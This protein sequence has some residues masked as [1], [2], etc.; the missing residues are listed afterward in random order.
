MD[1]AMTEV[2][3]RAGVVPIVLVRVGAVLIARVTVVRRSLRK[4][5]QAAWVFAA[6][7]LSTYR[8]AASWLQAS[9]VAAVTASSSPMS[10][11]A[12]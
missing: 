7:A 2:A 3:V 11:V 4:K 12:R 5:R 9:T 1:T 10:V 6:L 8:R